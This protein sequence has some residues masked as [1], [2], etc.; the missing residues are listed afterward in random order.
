MVNAIIIWFFIFFTVFLAIAADIFALNSQPINTKKNL[1]VNA[2]FFEIYSGKVF[3]LLNNKERLR[4]LEDQKQQVQI[5]G[6]SEME[7]QSVEDVLKLIES[8]NH[9]RCVYTCSE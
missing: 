1:S 9:C 8:G 2:S 3:D 6:L 7:V 5:V 4:I